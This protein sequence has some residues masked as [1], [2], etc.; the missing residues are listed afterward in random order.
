MTDCESRFQRRQRHHRPLD[1]AK[2]VCLSFLLREDQFDG[3]VSMLGKLE[4]VEI[5]RA[6]WLPFL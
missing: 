1:P 4:I 6:C 2:E 5:P 3:V